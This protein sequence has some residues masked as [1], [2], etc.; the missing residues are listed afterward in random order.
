MAVG[1][2]IYFY[3]DVK[4]V[5]HSSLAVL[6]AAMVG[7]AAVRGP[8]RLAAALIPA[9]GLCPDGVLVI[10]RRRLRQGGAHAIWLGPEIKV[11]AVNDGLGN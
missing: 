6:I 4:P 10:D 11:R 5:W 3:L 2:A 9:G 1:I 7:A 8:V